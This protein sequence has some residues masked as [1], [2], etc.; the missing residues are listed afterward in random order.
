MGQEKETGEIT[1][2]NSRKEKST[3]R[4]KEWTEKRKFYK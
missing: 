2:K 3:Q 4:E 1:E